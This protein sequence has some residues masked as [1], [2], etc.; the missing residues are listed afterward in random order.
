MKTADKLNQV[1]KHLHDLTKEI[2]QVETPYQEK[3]DRLYKEMEKATRQLGTRIEIAKQRVDHLE[4]LLEKEKDTDAK[5]AFEKTPPTTAAEFF[6]W[7]KLFGADYYSSRSRSK[8]ICTDPIERAPR[9][10]GLHIMAAT[11]GYSGGYKIY[12]AFQGAQVYAWLLIRTPEHMA[13]DMR[14]VA[15]IQ[16]RHVEFKH[17]YSH[18]TGAKVV[19]KPIAAWKEALKESMLEGT[20]HA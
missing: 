1:K 18:S 2:E 6:T 16:G 13:D 9:V 20:T 12:V 5:K 15:E 11:D 14:V 19:S 8:I 7:Q 17:A 10:P 4:Q 3:I